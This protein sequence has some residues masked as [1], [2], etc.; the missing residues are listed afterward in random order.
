MD[1][2]KKQL[3]EKLD[4]AENGAKHTDFEA[5]HPLAIESTFNEVIEAIRLDKVGGLVEK[6]EVLLDEL[7]PEKPETAKLNTPFMPSKDGK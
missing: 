5:G 4:G 2:L 3:L 7:I 1:D 6:A